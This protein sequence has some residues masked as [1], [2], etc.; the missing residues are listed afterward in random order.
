MSGIKGYPTQQKL[1]HSNQSSRHD[2]VTAQPADAGLR[3]SLDVHAR[4]AY[5]VGSPTVA[6]TAAANTGNPSD[7]GGT[8]VY[9]TSTPARVGDFVRFET[10]QAARLEISIVD[11]ST[12]HFVLGAKLPSTLVPVATDTFFI[13]RYVTQLTDENGQQIVVA[14][15]GPVQF[16]LNGSDVEVEQ[17]TGTPANSNPLPVRQLNTSGVAF[18]AATLAE[19]QLQTTALAAVNASLDAIEA[20]DFATEAKQDNIITELQVIGGAINTDGTAAGADG[21]LI[22]GTD[23]ANFQS[24][25]VDSSGRPNVNVIASALPTGAATEAKQDSQ[26]TELQNIELD[27][28]AAVI[29]L[30]ALNTVDFATEAKQDS[31]ITELQD[32]EADIE[33]MSSK[34]PATLGQKAMAASLAVVLASDQSALP[35]RSPVNTT[36][37]C[38]NTSLTAT[39]ASTATAPANA[40]GFILEAPSD[41][42]DNVRYRIGGTAST[43]AGMLME[44]G[45]D[46]GFIPC[47]ANVSVCATV[48][49]TNAFS[50]Q[51]IMSA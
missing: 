40:V 13:M 26:I 47:A 42:T 6:R 45:R 1:S 29:E 25:S 14:T 33:S 43:S 10:G 3:Q 37:Q 46:T 9:D 4:F 48:S 8:I 31:Q 7:G 44:P 21:Y 49:G 30:T 11:V 2:F 12:N 35:V 51:W 38:D 39:T 20:V 34:L 24:M 17:D 16:V 50:I 36:G 15:P 5:R 22:G 23:G 19:Q 41:N 32:I 28:E 27:V 18:N